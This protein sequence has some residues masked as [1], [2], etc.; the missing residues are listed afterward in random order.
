M[1]SKMPPT[2]MR[3]PPEV[4]PSL[5]AH[6]NTYDWNVKWEKHDHDTY[7]KFICS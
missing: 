1:K 4:A 6:I 5:I 3:V 2:T 7:T